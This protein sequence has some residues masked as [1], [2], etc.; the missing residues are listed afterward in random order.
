V[1]ENNPKLARRRLLIMAL[2]LALMGAA[3][4]VSLALIPAT[5]Q[6]ASPSALTLLPEPKVLAEFQLVDH[7]GQTFSLDDLRGAW[8]L[9]FFGFT[10]CP[11]VCPGALYDLDLLSAQLPGR[12]D[13]GEALH[14]VI[15]VSVDPER[16]TPEALSRYVSYFNPQFIGVTGA[17][18]QLAALAANLGIAYRIA[19]HEPGAE[20]YDVL[21]SSSVVLISPDGRLQGAFTAPLDVDQTARELTTLF[22][23]VD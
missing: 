21:H 23:R 22:A 5:R 7:S 6:Q 9:M 8:S 14:R 16:D 1:Q 11:D 3:T 18:E 12:A 10:N 4:G 17:A 19:E 13:N 20:R 15:F 2:S